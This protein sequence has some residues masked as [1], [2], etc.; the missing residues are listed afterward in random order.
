MQFNLPIKGVSEGTAEDRPVPLTSGHINNMRVRD[1][2]EKK[3]RLS[4]RPGL[5][6]VFSEQVGGDSFPIVFV[7]VITTID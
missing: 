7:G 5:D 6:K 3:I 4:Q 1:V 2:L